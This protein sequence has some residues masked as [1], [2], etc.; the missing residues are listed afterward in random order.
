M[1]ATATAARIDAA[2]AR[3]A[4]RLAGGT[5]TTNDAAESVV[6]EFMTAIRAHV[7]HTGVH[8]GIGDT[9]DAVNEVAAGLMARLQTNPID[10]TYAPAQRATYVRRL[11]AG[12]YLD[13]RRAAAPLPRREWLVVERTA[14]HA[15]KAHAAGTDF[16]AEDRDSYVRDLCAADEVLRHRTP[17]W[18]EA[19]AIPAAAQFVALDGTIRPVGPRNVDLIAAAAVPS[20]GDTITAD[21]LVD[22]FD[23]MCDELSLN[24][25]QRTRAAARLADELAAAC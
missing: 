14:A 13:T 22:Q 18:V 25:R 6:V 24:S 12:V 20:A 4:A 16:T 9:E 5:T 11:I 15:A 2:R 10:P 21:R 8:R 7:A 3:R 23:A 1:E 19:V 17:R